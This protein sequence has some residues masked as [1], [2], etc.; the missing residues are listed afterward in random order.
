MIPG[1]AGLV[2]DRAQHYPVDRIANPSWNG[3]VAKHIRC[4]PGPRATPWAPDRRRIRASRPRPLGTRWTILFGDEGSG[5][6]WDVTANRRNSASTGSPTGG[7]PAEEKHDRLRQSRA[8]RG[9]GARR[10]PSTDRPA[11]IDRARCGGGRMHG[12]RSHGP[13]HLPDL[14]TDRHTS[15]H[16][17]ADGDG[18]PNRQRYPDPNPHADTHAGTTAH[19]D[20]PARPDADPRA[21]QLIQTGRDDPEFGRPLLAGCPRPFHSHLPAEEHR[22]RCLHDQGQ[23]SGGAAERRRFDPHPRA[24]G[25][26]I[27]HAEARPRRKRPHDG[28]DRKPVR[29]TGDCSPGQSGIRDPR[30]RRGRGHSPLAHGRG[31]RAV[32]HGREVVATPLSPTDEGGVPSCM[33]DPSVYSGSIDMQPWTP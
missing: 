29:R 4:R 5:T 17:H 2:P 11:G 20:A 1:H 25:G 31:R 18:E 3:K 22:H 14:S 7:R 6:I 13:D 19:T 28:P 15:G 23:E 27:R 9:A 26:D 21:V 10:P 8:C 12:S 16:S 24:G 33:G 32:V 30:N